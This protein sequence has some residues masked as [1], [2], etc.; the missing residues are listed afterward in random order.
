MELVLLILLG[1]LEE[2]SLPLLDKTVSDC[3][4]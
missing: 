4:S 1:S 3:W 2:T